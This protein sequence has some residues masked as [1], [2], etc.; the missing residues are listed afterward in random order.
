MQGC[1][2]LEEL[3]PHLAGVAGH[4]W[5][6]VWDRTA[7][8]T[9]SSR[10]RRGSR[11]REVVWASLSSSL[12]RP[13]L[14]HFILAVADGAYALDRARISHAC[15]AAPLPIGRQLDRKVLWV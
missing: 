2:P 6:I 9:L 13:A 5:S 3:Y 14:S 15:Q 11:V 10:L 8:R 12:S 7:R 4:P 1:R